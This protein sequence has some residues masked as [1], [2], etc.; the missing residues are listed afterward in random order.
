MKWTKQQ[1]ENHPQAYWEFVFRKNRLCCAI[2]VVDWE[3]ER[4]KWAK[5]NVCGE[6]EGKRSIHCCMWT[7][8]QF[9]VVLTSVH[10]I[11]CSFMSL[12]IYHHLMLS[13]FRPQPNGFSTCCVCMCVFSTPDCGVVVVF[14]PLYLCVWC[15]VKYRHELLYVVQSAF[16]LNFEAGRLLFG[17]LTW[18][19]PIDYTQ[20]T[21]NHFFSLSVLFRVCVIFVC[22]CVCQDVTIAFEI[23]SKNFQLKL[24]YCYMIDD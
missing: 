10:F 17:R 21:L 9:S 20:K 5:S 23:F 3:R 7:V 22:V 14:H 11:Q 1:R 16:Q 15:M 8:W 24:H 19:N 18:T 4:K 12:A 2:R 6:M 13:N